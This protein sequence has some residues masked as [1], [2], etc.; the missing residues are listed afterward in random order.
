ML[1]LL[2]GERRYTP[3]YTMETVRYGRVS[4]GDGWK[5]TMFKVP[6]LPSSSTQYT[7]RFCLVETY[8]QCFSGF[9]IGDMNMRCFSTTFVPASFG[10]A[11]GQTNSQRLIAAAFSHAIPGHASS[12]W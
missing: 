8:A 5:S 3:A 7:F 9:E 10:T 4:F 1:K 6:K 2:L 12:S 11:S